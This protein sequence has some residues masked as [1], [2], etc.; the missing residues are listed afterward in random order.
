[1][2]RAGL[3][4]AAIVL[5]WGCGGAPAPSTKPAPAPRVAVITP[6]ALELEPFL[7]HATII[8]R[9]IVA[10][11]VHHLGTLAGHDAV[12]VRCGRSLVAS[13]AATQA[14]LDHHD[15][16]AVLVSGIAGGVDPGRHVGDVVVPARTH[17]T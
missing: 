2:G 3:A 9:R 6:L 13:A 10:G 7:E 4:C 1:M 5:A 17:A 15:V 12:L 16:S 11:Q 8:E 14:V